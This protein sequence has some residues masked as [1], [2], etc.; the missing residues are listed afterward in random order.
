LFTGVQSNK[1]EGMVVWL[2]KREEKRKKTVVYMKGQ[3]KKK[4]PGAFHK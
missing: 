4:G 3:E 1:K 2:L